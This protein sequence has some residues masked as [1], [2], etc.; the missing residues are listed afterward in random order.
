[1]ITAT[2]PVALAASTVAVLTSFGF[3]ATI[4]RHR[5][6][7]TTSPMIGIA[8]ALFAG[9]LL[10]LAVVDVA[11]V[12]HALGIQ[13]TPT[14][15]PGG[16]WTLIAF[17]LPAIVGV[18]W[19]LFALQYT[20]RDRKATPI[21]LS[22]VVVLLVLLIAP[23]VALAMVG[24]FVGISTSTFNTVLGMTIV[25][26]D[27]LAV[28]GVFLI[29]ATTLRHKAFPATQT[30][31]LT[32]AISAILTLPFITTTLQE[33]IATPLAIT[34]SALLFTTVIRRY[35]VFETLPVVSIAG[36]D[37]VINEMSDGIVLVGADSTIRD[38]NPA[39][40]S[41]FDISRDEA[42]GAPLDTITATLPAPESLA[43]SEPQDIRVDSGRT[44]SVTAESVT[45]TRNRTL[46]HLLVCRDITDA[47]RREHRLSVLTQL[48]AD[49]TTDQMRTVTD[50]AD[51]IADDD[52][53]ATEGGARIQKTATDTATLVGR[54]RS[55][56][57][58]LADR[59]PAQ[60]TTTCLQELLTDIQN[61]LGVDAPSAAAGTPVQ[62]SANRSLVV[63]ILETLVT[64]AETTG[65]TVSLQVDIDD[66][67]VT[68][69]VVPYRHRDGNTIPS[70]A[71]DI[72]R[73]AAEHTDW[74]VETK[75]IDGVPAV[76]VRLP[77][78]R[79]KTRRNA[80]RET[81]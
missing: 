20:G 71:L 51:A 80:E 35:R 76:C 42:T 7:P 45:N 10:H 18:L 50:I 24:A 40:E 11:P 15:S 30:A 38:L 37:R 68:I 41:L 44:V 17:D 62:V 56:E 16:F 63:A 81:A 6:D 32:L 66:E 61:T 53:T 34:T 70:R 22:A 19:F 8:V 75:T 2:G 69:G 21:A 78:R 47:R 33:P 27:S 67:F 48:V 60:A 65:T 4:L 12:R 3:V 58:A 29:C 28:I 73:L 1:M 72:A 55:V 49:A 26:A 31:A 39:A 36:R 52:H 13:W 43:E 74:T 77:T 54:V 5:H 25:L 57:R 64:A 59:D 79:A 14:E 46:G 9:A 23:N